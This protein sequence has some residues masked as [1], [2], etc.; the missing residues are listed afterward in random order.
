MSFL[1]QSKGLENQHKICGKENVKICCSSIQNTNTEENE[2]KNRK[3]RQ[4]YEPNG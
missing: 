4:T 2:K 3:D 1:I